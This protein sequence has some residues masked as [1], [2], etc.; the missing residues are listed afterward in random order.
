[1]IE[2]DVIISGTLLEKYDTNLSNKYFQKCIASNSV[3]GQNTLEISL[4][5]QRHGKF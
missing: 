1:M 4:V 3:T 2:E 5:I